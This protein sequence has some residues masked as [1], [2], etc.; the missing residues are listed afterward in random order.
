MKNILGG[1]L[2]IADGFGSADL[3]DPISSPTSDKTISQA[4]IQITR[5][6]YHWG[7]TLGVA[8]GPITFG[9]AP[10][11]AGYSVTGHNVSGFSAFT[12][13]EQA[14]ARAALAFWSS[15]S[16]ITFSDQGNTNNATILFR[17]YNDPNDSSEAFAFYPSSNNQVATS[18][19]GDVFF[20]LAFANANAINPGTYEWESMIHEIGHAARVGAPRGVQRG[21]WPNNYLQ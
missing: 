12:A 8:T 5:D 15:V 18:S 9:F 17:N 14:A 21:T 1:D 19:D 2:F 6:N 16:G 4:G 10:S 20:N 11:A 13:S 7:T 3:G